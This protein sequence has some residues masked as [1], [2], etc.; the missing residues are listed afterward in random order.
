MNLF[1]FDPSKYD[2]GDIGFHC[3]DEVSFNGVFDILEKMGF[4]TVLGLA[5]YD[6]KD[7]NLITCN[8]LTDNKYH[9]YCGPLENYN[10]TSGIY[11]IRIK[12]VNKFNYYKIVLDHFNLIEI[13]DSFI[14]DIYDY[15]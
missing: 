7:H 13:R 6:P 5:D 11:K 4:P 14:Y 9:I 12:Y 10:G 15:I 1:N 2:G 3:N 8:T